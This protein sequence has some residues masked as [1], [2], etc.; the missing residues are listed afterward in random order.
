MEIPKIFQS[1]IDPSQL[2]LTIRGLAVAII[3]VLLV[4]F[5]MYNINVTHQDLN[6]IVEAIVNVITA[7]SAVVSAIMVAWGLIR[8]IGVAFSWIKTNE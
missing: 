1:S 3:P 7:L 8:K 6:G 5:Q 4:L 2:S